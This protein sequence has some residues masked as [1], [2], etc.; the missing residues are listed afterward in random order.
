MHLVNPLEHLI[1]ARQLTESAEEFTRRLPPGRSPYDWLWCANPHQPLQK[2]KEKQKEPDVESFEEEGFALL[3]GYLKMRTHLEQTNPSSGPAAITNKMRSE[4]EAL[5]A[6]IVKT[7]KEHGVTSGKWML[8]P[9]LDDA[10]RVWKQVCEAVIN[11]RLGNMAKIAAMANVGSRSLLI[12]IYTADFSD[13]REVRR[14]VEELV[15]MGFVSPSSGTPSLFGTIYYKCDAYTHLGIDSNNQYHLKAS[16]YNSKDILSEVLKPEVSGAGKG[17]GKQTT[18]GQVFFNVAAKE[19]EKPSRTS[20][21]QNVRVGK[22]ASPI[23]SNVQTR[24]RLHTDDTEPASKRTKLAG[25]FS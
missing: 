2:G 5:Q 12:C 6:G 11:N 1:N 23:T 18:L 7:A 19:N 9:T 13:V 24:K 25:N 17:S 14:V 20:N 10:P 15:S 4:R 3:H 21:I 22:D 8:F 16:I